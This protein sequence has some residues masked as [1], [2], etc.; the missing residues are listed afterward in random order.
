S[1]QAHPA[2]DT[3]I[4]RE[5]SRRYEPLHGWAA[6]WPCG[7][8]MELSVRQLSTLL[9]LCAGL[10]ACPAAASVTLLGFAPGSSG[11]RATGVSA[12]G[13]TVA[14]CSDNGPP[15]APGF[16]WSTALGRYD[17][18]LEPGL[19]ST[20]AAYGISGDGTTV[21]GNAWSNASP[22][23]RAFRWRASPGGG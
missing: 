21:V 5:H 7:R 22:D 2:F 11:S 4:L 10:L 3:A 13:S 20:T 8:F 6:C 15:V 1:R 14:G 12:S 9:F 16:I 23:P 17:F 18:G 19:L